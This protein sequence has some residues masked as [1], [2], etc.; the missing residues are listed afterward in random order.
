MTKFIESINGYGIHSDRNANPITPIVENEYVVFGD[1]SFASY[2]GWDRSDYIDIS[3]YDVAI[4]FRYSGTGADT[5]RNNAFYDSDKNFVSYFMMSFDSEIAIPSSAR[6]VVVS[7]DSENLGKT[8]LVNADECNKRIQNKKIDEASV[9]IKSLAD[10]IV[11]N[12]YIRTS[13]G[14]F[15]ERSGWRRTDYIS[16]SKVGRYFRMYLTNMDTYSNNAYAFYDAEH[17]FIKAF[18]VTSNTEYVEVPS[19]AAFFAISESGRN[20]DNVYVEANVNKWGYT[21]E[22]TIKNTS[23]EEIA[24]DV[25]NNEYV[26]NSG[27]FVKYDNWSRTDYIPCKGE[28]Y[29][30]VWA[31][32]RST[33]ESPSG[34]TYNWFYNASKEPVSKFNVYPLNDSRHALV[35][36][37]NDAEYFVLSNGTSNL[38]GTVIKTFTHAAMSSLVNPD[39][40]SGLL[41][42]YY[43]SYMADKVSLLRG[44]DDAISAN[45]DRFVFIT[46]CH[47]YASHDNTDY[48]PML[49]KHLQDRVGISMVVFGGDGVDAAPREPQMKDR[50][51]KFIR[52]FGSIE[53]FFPIA[54]NHEFY[55]DWDN[56]GSYKGGITRSEVY[57]HFI[58]QVEPYVDDGDGIAAY[59]VDSK[60]RKMRYYFI[61]CDYDMN[62]PDSTRD[63]VLDTL[64]HVPEGY[65]VVVFTHSATNNTVTSM[66]TNFIPI[67]DGLVSMRDKEQYSYGGKTYDYSSVDAVPA[68]VL[69]GHTHIDGSFVYNG[70]PVVATTCD[71]WY[72]GN[73]EGANRSPDTVSEQA[74][75]VVDIDKSTKTV[76]MTRIGEGVNRSFT[77]Q[78]N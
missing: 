23:N 58:K 56:E 45:G 28:V 15:T 78:S 39:S 9:S 1:G 11:E 24:F 50:M 33:A 62:F 52:K 22:N 41:P 16:T 5:V 66:R 47:Y 46:D 34:S 13:D 75:D 42:S 19:N 26:D 21:I 36:I 59:Y 18:T 71:N 72:L 68:L 30:D 77:Y 27:E 70:I 73:V 65:T 69:C 54:G 37:P 31:A 74:F 48:G 60:I 10:S 8:W 61:S 53:R 49:I 40:A 2:N 63:W 64:L 12:E 51:G 67:A 4:K 17:N 38:I 14:A 25:V 43:D 44:R 7:W 57:M 6:Y 3:D 20:M 32:Y 29:L 55:S 35:N 76:Y